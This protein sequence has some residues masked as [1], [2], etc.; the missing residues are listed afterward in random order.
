LQQLVRKASG[1]FIWAATAYRFIQQVERAFLIQKRL[2]AILRAGNMMAEE[3]PEN[4][5][6]EI[7]KTVLR[8]TVPTGCASEEKEEFMS[9]LKNVLGCIVTLFS[10]LSIRSLSRLLGIQSDEVDDCLDGLH[11]ILDIPNDGSRL[12]RLHHPSFRDFL[13]DN[14]RCND[15]NFWVDETHVNETLAA[16]CIELM[17]NSLKEDVCGV[18]IPG[19]FVTDIE[20]RHMERCIPLEVQYACLYWVQHLRRGGSRL[21]DDDSAARFLRNHLLH[22]LEALGWM[23]KLSEGIL[24]ISSLESI[25]QVSRMNINQRRLN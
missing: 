5:L 14:D 1:L 17:S 8:H 7:Y 10:P 9:M 2:A 22:W 15:A 4:H 20:S 12:V 16:H 24:E 11:A 3:Q 25:V 21:R 18:T 19:T 13:L 23:Q 6:N